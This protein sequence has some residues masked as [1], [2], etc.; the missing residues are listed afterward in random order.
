[1]LSQPSKKKEREREREKGVGQKTKQ[2]K[3]L[4][5]QPPTHNMRN[6]KSVFIDRIIRVTY[7][8]TASTSKTELVTQLKK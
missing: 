5:N 3:Q 8:A 1:M 6:Q 2:A 7:A 4:T